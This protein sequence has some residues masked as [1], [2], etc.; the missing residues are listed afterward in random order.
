[1][2]LTIIHP[3]QVFSFKKGRILNEELRLPK[4]SQKNSN[5][6]ELQVGEILERNPSKLVLAVHLYQPLQ[7]PM[8]VNVGSKGIVSHEFISKLN[9]CNY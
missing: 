3:C 6:M 5:K 8:K 1:M 7:S 9:S 2:R 4:R